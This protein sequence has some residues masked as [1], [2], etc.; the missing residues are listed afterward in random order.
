MSQRDV[1]ILIAAVFITAGLIL[2][3]IS[4]PMFMSAW[5]EYKVMCPDGNTKVECH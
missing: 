1:L 3:A 2:C 4:V 5:N